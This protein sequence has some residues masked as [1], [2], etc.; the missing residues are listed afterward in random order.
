MVEF[1]KAKGTSFVNKPV[2]VN[3][4]NTG[5]VE[6]GQTLARV[7]QQLATQFFADAEQEQI[8]LGKEVGLTLPVRDD[9]GNLAFQ[10]TPTSLSDVAKNAAE[11]IIQKRYEDALNVDIFSKLNEIRQKSRTSSEFSKNVENEMS[12]YIEQTKLSGGERYVGGMTE[13]VAKLSAQHFNAMATEETKEAMRI[14]SLQAN[15]INNLNIADLISIAG[16]QINKANIGELDN[17][18]ED[19]ESNSQAI[20][21]QNNNNL[22]TNNLAVDTHRKTDTS[23]KTA[24][25]FALVNILTKDKTPSQIHEIENFFR[26][27]TLP[28]DLSDKEKVLLNKIESSPYRNEVKK[29]VSSV[30]DKVSET[31]RQLRAD[32]NQ[33]Y[34]DQQRLISQYRND[35]TIYR[36]SQQFKARFQM[37]LSSIHNEI[38]TNGGVASDEQKNKIK[39]LEDQLFKATDGTGVI[40]NGQRILLGR[41]EA[42]SAMNEAVVMGLENTIVKSQLFKTGGDLGKLQD[43][44]YQRDPRLLSAEQ[45]KIYN[46]VIEVSGAS[47]QKDSIINATGKAIN[48]NITSANRA[49]KELAETILLQNNFNNASGIGTARFGNTAKEQQ[50]LSK[51]HNINAPYFLQTFEDELRTNT[52]RAVELNNQMARGN[53]TSAFIDFMDNAL[54]GRDEGEI[55][56]AMNYFQ[57]YTQVQEG[58]IRVD[59]LSGVLS[60]ESFAL[61]S[62][63]AKLI[64]AYRGKQ[65]F[66]DVE[67][68]DGGPV[69]QAQMLTKIKQVYQARTQPESISNFKSNLKSIIGKESNSFDY[70]TNTLGFDRTEAR[71]LQFIVDMSASMGLSKKVT[72]E[73]LTISKDGIYLDG[74][75]TVVDF[76]AGGDNAF[77]SK[78][79]FKAV[80]GAEEDG[81]ARSIIQRRLNDLEHF[82]EKVGPDGKIVKRP[83]GSFTLM[84]KPTQVIDGKVQYSTGTRTDAVQPDV[85]D[86]P[87]YLQPIPYGSRKDDVRYVAVTQKGDFFRPIRLPDGSLMAFDAKELRRGGLGDN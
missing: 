80:F 34:V 6:A 20:V 32:Q 30:Q 85:L 46:T 83:V 82:V 13:T 5:A 17:V 68:R 57:K 35:P 2:G 79:A 54:T 62:I 51:S 56:R 7:G 86:T 22:V 87:V 8:K 23:A 16:D 12:V 42:M 18:L 74:E 73:I 15:Q 36:N 69:T 78:Y 1:L 59:K 84:Y 4:V 48:D 31:A 66:F 58:G 26:T 76:Y 24:V 47:L 40:I 71:D 27:G 37:E 77:R 11:P 81:F 10:T 63:A 64:P 67:G 55:T 25:S 43:A 53:F 33:K 3:N 65:Q 61:Y 14:S 72:D 60:E 41:G 38:F 70:L 21:E 44:L 45:K 9:D 28:K 29:Y 50:N 49:D 19:L 39:N 52:P 75:S